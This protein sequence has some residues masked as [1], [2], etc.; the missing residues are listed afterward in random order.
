[1]PQNLRYVILTVLAAC[2]LAAGVSPF[3]NYMIAA[4]A[5]T[6]SANLTIIDAK[7][8]NLSYML[9]TVDGSAFDMN[10]RSIIGFDIPDSE[11]IVNIDRLGIQ[12]KYYTYAWW[13]I[14]RTKPQNNEA[15]A[16]I[17]SSE[18]YDLVIQGLNALTLDVD[19][20]AIGIPSQ[21]TNGT[22]TYSSYDRDNI[23]KTK[24]LA[25][26]WYV[27]LPFNYTYEEIF[28]SIAAQREDGTDISDGTNDGD[29]FIDEDD[30]SYI[31]FDLSTPYIHFPLEASIQY[32]EISSFLNA[33]GKIGGIKTLFGDYDYSLNRIENLQIQ[34]FYS[35]NIKNATLLTVPAFTEAYIES[36]N[37]AS[38]TVRI[39]YESLQPALSYNI[40]D[41]QGNLPD[42]V[43]EP[44]VPGIFDW[45]DDVREK[46]DEIIVWFIISIVVILASALI[47]NVF[48]PIIRLFPRKKSL[49]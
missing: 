43:N 27:I 11:Q 21:L 16:T 13:D 7:Q 12:A 9:T 20:P 5:E 18:T 19:V 1:M 37:D 32:I 44:I 8:E 26:D 4:S 36:Y 14:F 33:P 31:E 38:A 10:S 40:R 3:K 29:F 35:E 24:F 15:T 42:P 34:Y 47:I 2:S 25:K 28:I 6:T 41:E 30:V 17:N 48:I 46:I 22:F 49:R 39:G 23:Q 45:W